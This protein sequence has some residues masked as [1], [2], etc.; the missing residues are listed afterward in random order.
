MKLK[1]QNNTLPNDKKQKVVEVE[2]YSICNR[3]RNIAFS[4]IKRGLVIVGLS[5]LLLNFSHEEKHYVSKIRINEDIEEDDITYFAEYNL[6]KVYICDPKDVSKVKRLLDEND[7]LV[8]DKRC[9]DNPD[10]CIYNSCEIDDS[11][12][13]VDV[14]CILEEY[15]RINPTDWNRSFKSMYNEWLVH[16]M[17][18]SINIRKDST[19]HVDLDNDDEKLFDSS[20]LYKILRK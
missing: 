5:L 18:Y 16:N 9:T 3:K 4:A 1:E 17:F 2:P 10:M 7:I 15:E 12:T 8:I 13:I 6:G 11:Q 14:L 19:A 20:I